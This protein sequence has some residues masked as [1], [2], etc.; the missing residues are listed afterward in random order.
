MD[1]LWEKGCVLG[2]AGSDWMF[3]VTGI[4]LSGMVTL[5]FSVTS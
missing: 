5:L 3:L 2:L 4:A 1:I